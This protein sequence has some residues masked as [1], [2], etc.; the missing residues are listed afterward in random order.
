MHHIETTITKQMTNCAKPALMKTVL[1]RFL[2]PI[3]S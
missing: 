2:W 3:F 1:N